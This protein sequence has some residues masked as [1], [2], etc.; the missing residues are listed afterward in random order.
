MIRTFSCALVAVT[1]LAGSVLAETRVKG[2]IK[3]VDAAKGVVTVTIKKK[4]QEFQVTD[5]TKL[6]AAPEGK[7]IKERLKSPLFKE[8]NEVAVTTDTKDGKEVVIL[9]R[10]YPPK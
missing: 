1:I 10:L 4:D 3:S 8:G 9:I 6:T 5:D 7:R 2:V